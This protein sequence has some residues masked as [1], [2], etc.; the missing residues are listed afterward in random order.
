MVLISLFDSS[1]VTNPIATSY[2]AAFC[3]APSWG[4]QASGKEFL[5]AITTGADFTYR[6]NRSKRSKAEK[7]NNKKVFLILISFSLQTTF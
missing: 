3:S 1:K 5:N 4:V 7:I 2:S 6:T